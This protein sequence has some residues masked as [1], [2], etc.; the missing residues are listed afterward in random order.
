MPTF[1]FTQTEPER[2]LT[3][4]RWDV[5]VSTWLE[6]KFNQGLNDRLHSV[7]GR[8]TEDAIYSGPT[9]SAKLANQ[10]YSLPGLEFDGP[11]QQEDAWLRHQRKRRELTRQ[12]YFEAATHSAFSGKAAAGFA[13]QMLGNLLSPL[14]AGLMFLPVVGS[15]ARAAGV[16]KVGGGPIRQ[17]LARGLIAE[18]ALATR[19][20]FPKFTAAAI[21][22]SV[23]NLAGEVP[24]YIQNKRDQAEYGLGDAAINVLAG[25]LF[26]GG[27]RVGLEGLGRLLERSSRNYAELSPATR[28]L[29]LQKAAD[30]FAH[31][32]DI[33]VREFVAIDEAAIQARVEADLRADIDRAIAEDEAP[34]IPSAEPERPF[35]VIDAIEGYTGEKISISNAKQFRED[36]APTGAA[37]NLFTATGSKLDDVLSSLHAQ[38]LFRRIESDE[39]LL[40]AILNAAEA[41]KGFR[42]QLRDE[43]TL[44]PEQ[45]RRQRMADAERQRRIDAITTRKRAEFEANREKLVDAD[46]AAEIR[47]QQEQGRILDSATV[48]RYAAKEQPTEQDLAILT[49]DIATIEADLRPYADRLLSEDELGAPYES[50]EAAIEAALPCVLE[51]LAKG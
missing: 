4:S 7:V 51:S 18:E 42:E 9:I 13:T 30:D 11:V 33:D 49:E 27:L 32:R 44:T 41:R 34:A 24:L 17:A 20:P 1:A 14:D 5:P 48:A 50:R 23:G 43:R 36:F 38:G 10:L 37:R 8:M 19:I 6:Q 21:D 40:D 31:N 3:I 26:A 46:M 29:M 39:E 28:D 35:D 22:G 2:A 16:A 15:T 12:S 45:D 25:G 47:R